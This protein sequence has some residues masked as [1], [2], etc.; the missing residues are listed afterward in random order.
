[1]KMMVPRMTFRFTMA[2]PDHNVK[3]NTTIRTADL[4]KIAEMFG[5]Q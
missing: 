1:M 3:L 4:I 2:L 5:W